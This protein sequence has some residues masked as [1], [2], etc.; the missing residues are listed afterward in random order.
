MNINRAIRSIF[1]KK[2][3]R[4]EYRQF[5]ND[6]GVSN[7]V[8]SSKVGIFNCHAEFAD[9]T[10]VHFI[11]K[12]KTVSII[13]NGIKLLCSGDPVLFLQLVLN[14]RI[15]GYN[16]SSTREAALYG[17]FHESLKRYLP[18]FIGAHIHSLTG[19]CFIAIQE[20][21]Q[22]PPE[23]ADIPELADIIAE[24]H[25]RY[26]CDEREARRLGVNVYSRRTYR[27]SRYVFRHMLDN[28]ENSAFSGE[29][30]DVILQFIGDIHIEYDSVCRHRTLTHNDFS[31]RNISRGES[32]R[33]YDW[34]LACFQNPEHDILELLISMLHRLDEE[35]IM[36]ALCRHRRRLSELTGSEL[37]D[38][39]YN[40]ALRFSL[41]E[42]CVNKLSIIRLAGKR[43]GLDYTEQLA[44]NTSRMMDILNITQKEVTN[45]TGT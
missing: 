31:C 42:F 11:G 15:L 45:A 6:S 34:E 1:H 14:H 2:C 18:E 24:F 40:A 20:L 19:T 36:S 29:Q 35:Q 37:S 32:I 26:Y 12:R 9:G 21:P 39:E 28:L 3:L 13:A 17:G 4:T 8:A 25:A 10:N 22:I 7:R 44:V 41:L 5:V 23:S 33:I 30:L 27:R 43:L 38:K 16:G